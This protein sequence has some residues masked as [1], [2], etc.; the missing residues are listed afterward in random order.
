[1]D[2]ITDIIDKLK[3]KENISFI[4]Y[5]LSPEI[6]ADNFTRCFLAE[7]GCPDLNGI[8]IVE[9]LLFFEKKDIFIY[10]DDN[11]K[12]IIGKDSGGLLCIDRYDGKVWSVDPSGEYP[13]CF[14]NSNISDFIMWLYY[15]KTY[16][17]NI[18]SDLN[19][20]EEMIIYNKLIDKFSEIDSALL[21]DGDN[22]W[23]Q[24]TEPLSYGSF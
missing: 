17:I 14:V 4:K 11:N 13:E 9:D 10:S 2:C 22:W 16:Y 3:N 21:S 15:Y 20:A 23:C 24:V 7:Y 5:D 8:F 6:I 19:E 1:M 18:S 12:L